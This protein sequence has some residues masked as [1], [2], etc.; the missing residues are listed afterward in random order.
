MR[1]Q[2]IK[3]LSKGRSAD[4]VDK[5]L[6]RHMKTNRR[7]LQNHKYRKMCS[8][9]DKSGSVPDRDISHLKRCVL[10]NAGFIGQHLFADA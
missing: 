4:K 9:K 5:N 6:V 1:N 8:N 3:E 7:Y 10:K 2:I